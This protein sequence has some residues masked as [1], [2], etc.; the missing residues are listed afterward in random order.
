M[1]LWR[2]D[3]CGCEIEYSDPD[4]NVLKVHNR[5]NKHDGLHDD[6]SHFDMVLSHNRKK[7]SVHN[8]VIDHLNSTNSKVVPSM[9]STFYDDEDNLHVKGSGLNVLDKITVLTKVSD[10]LESTSLNIDN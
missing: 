1:T 9:V 3:T 8:V 10:I 2:P 6:A 5:C 7:N 4:M